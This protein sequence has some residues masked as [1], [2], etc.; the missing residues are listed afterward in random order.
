MSFELLIA[1]RN[2]GKAEEISSLLASL[3]IRVR[4]LQGFPDLPSVR[5]DGKTYEENATLKAK[6]YARMT[7]LIALADDS[8][9]EVDSLAGAPGVRSAR[10]AGHAASDGDRVRLLLDEMR[11]VRETGRAARFRCLVAIAEPSGNV[12]RVESGVCEGSIT[13]SPR[14]RGGFGFDPI[15]VPHGFSQTFAE[16]S[17][18]Q[19]NAISHRGKAMR[20]A[21]DFLRQMIMQT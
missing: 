20:A 17:P 14:G 12:F 6:A 11:S 21:R 10:Y 4:T 2:P 5:E 1:T 8:G 19:K 18:A 13:T 7:G 3:P 15:F 16:L 9:L